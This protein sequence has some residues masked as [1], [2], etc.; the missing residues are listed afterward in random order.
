MVRSIA[1]VA[2]AAAVK[3]AAQSSTTSSEFP[4]P[5]D[6][7][8][9]YNGTGPTMLRFGCH[10]LVIDRIDPLVA[11]GQV[12]SHHQHQIVGGDAFN[13]T[14]PHSDISALSTC[15][16]C[17]YSDDFSNY[18]TANL[19]FRAR[20][21]TY[22]RVPQIP[23][24]TDIFTNDTFI[25]QTN[26]G[27]TVYYVSPG[28]NQ[29]TAF[30]PG[31]RMFVGDATLRSPPD[32]PWDLSTQTCFRCFTGP[33]FGGN[34]LRPCLDPAVDT[35][36]LP[37]Q[38]CWGIRA[39]VLF[40]TCWDGVNLDSP[41]HKSHVAYPV[42]GPHIFDGIGT[43]DECPPSHPVKIPQVMLE[44]I[45]DTTPFNDPDEWP[46][47]GSQPFVL[48]TG[49]PTGYSQHGDYVFGWKDDA[50]QIAMEA[51]CFMA[52]CPGLAVQTVEQAAQCA[53]AE[54]AGDVY[55]GWLT[56]LPG[57]PVQPPV[58]TTSEAPEPTGKGKG[59]EGKGKKGK[60]KAKRWS[61]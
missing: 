59:D 3:V 24:H 1:A 31:F 22:K 13:A 23:N 9:T 47:D 39:N 18:W 40:P 51:G 49:D 32:S 46:E 19:Y 12:P 48:S 54:V 10:Q 43:A 6:D 45:W 11:P 16:T 28:Q 15:T 26:G 34:M 57:D 50:L 25:T 21:G 56:E 36:H 61:N 7:L 53:V 35:M 17:S 44:V 58:T 38:P 14:M 41:D 2:A 4:F 29:V 33:D 5:T 55:D 8:P 42:E 60:R 27:M 52:N 20:N 30:P 37:N